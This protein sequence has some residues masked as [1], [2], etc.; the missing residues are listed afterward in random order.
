MKSIYLQT[1][2][3][4]LFALIVTS[5]ETEIEFRGDDTASLLVVNSILSP[6]SAVKVHVSESKFFLKDDSSFENVNDAIVNLWVNGSL[7]EQLLSTGQGFYTG[8][9]IPKAGDIIK[10]TA[11]NN[12]FPEVNAESEIVQATPIVSV[13]TM[14]H[15]SD[16]YPIVNGYGNYLD[17]IGYSKMTEMKISL[18]FNDPPNQKNYYKI[19]VKLNQEYSDGSKYMRNYYF[20]SDDLVFGNTTEAGI[21]DE[22]SYRLYHE[23]N[24]DLF[25]G[26]NYSL[27]LNT[28]FI[29]IVYDNNP[30][31]GTSDLEPVEIVKNELILELQSISKSYYLYLKTRNAGSS[32][33]DFF[34]EPVQIYS[35]IEDGIGILGSYNTSRFK[36]DMPKTFTGEYYY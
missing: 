26:K 23:F 34:S 36:I 6:D 15:V 11:K 16:I 29:S 30:S 25:D 9:Y 8:N 3:F 19:A 24:D 4:S 28:S 33:I 21:F 31:G 14:I 5:C 13:D 18:K 1:I 2:I 20:S 17:T 7:Y 32:V 35:N 22:S 27:K 10:I 12:K